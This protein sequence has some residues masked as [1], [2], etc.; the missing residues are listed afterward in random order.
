MQG[1]N[2]GLLSEAGMPGIAD[3]GSKLISKIHQSGYTVIPHVGPSSIFLS[4]A[5]SGLNGQHFCFQGY[6]PIKENEF[7]N[8]LNQLI[9]L[10]EKFDQT[11][12]FIETPYRNDRMFQF[13]CRLTPKH[14]KLCVA[15]DL[16]GKNEHI[17]TL[18]IGQWQDS[19]LKIGKIPCIFL[20]GK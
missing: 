13:I 8:K 7:K 15:I 3:P 12:I 5:A 11:Q 17:K 19:K 1:H 9:S 2:V 6:L 10:V 18:S 16:S 4:L 14:I 20:L